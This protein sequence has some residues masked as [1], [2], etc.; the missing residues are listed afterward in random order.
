MPMIWAFVV[1]AMRSVKNGVAP[2][3]TFPRGIAI[4]ESVKRFPAICPAKSMGAPELLPFI[5][6]GYTPNVW[7]DEANWEGKDQDSCG[8][9]YWRRC[10]RGWRG[11]GWCVGVGR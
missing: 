11:D 3:L 5:W 7:L 6:I 8:R 2:Q 9:W 4:D 1:V 10:W